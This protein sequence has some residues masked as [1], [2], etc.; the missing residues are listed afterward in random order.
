[1][2]L[3]RRRNGYIVQGYP[4][5]WGAMFQLGAATVNGGRT[6]FVN[7][8]TLVSPEERPLVDKLAKT[9]ASLFPETPKK[10]ENASR[11]ATSPK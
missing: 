4:K 6:D 8:A 5:A 11:S 3:A 9:F 7:W 10:T 2:V 1:M